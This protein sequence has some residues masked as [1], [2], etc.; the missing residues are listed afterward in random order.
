MHRLGLRPAPAGSR[1][2][3]TTH[4]E[5]KV[6]FL[7]D[8]LHGDEEGG[9]EDDGGNGGSRAHHW[10]LLDGPQLSDGGRRAAW[11]PWQRVI[12]TRFTANLIVTPPCLPNIDQ[13]GGAGL[14]SP[15]LR[16]VCD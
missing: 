2:H 6:V 1:P 9:S 14:V 3:G 8:L 4:D 16:K 15:V 10:R 5:E 7:E 12:H 11:R 13:G